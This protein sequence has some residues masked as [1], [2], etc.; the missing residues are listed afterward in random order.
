MWQADD[1]QSR[2]RLNLVCDLGMQIQIVHNISCWQEREHIVLSAWIKRFFPCSRRL[3]LIISCFFLHIIHGRV[4]REWGLRRKKNY[5]PH[6]YAYFHGSGLQ[7]DTTNF[8]Y[9]I[10]SI[11]FNY[12]RKFIYLFF[13]RWLSRWATKRKRRK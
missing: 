12:A 6:K 1:E 8:F 2:I 7:N 4:Y 10:I 11:N 3:V 5:L 9:T 13:I